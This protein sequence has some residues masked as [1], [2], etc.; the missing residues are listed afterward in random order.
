MSKDKQM[1]DALK[2]GDKVD[3]YFSVAYKKPVIEYKYG[4]MFEFRAADKSG[5][6]TVKYWG[7]QDHRRVQELQESLDRGGVA[8]ITGEV[9]EYRNQ[10]EISISEK[11]GYTVEVLKPGGYEAS[12]LV[13]TLDGIPEMRDRL[14]EFVHIVEEPH[15]VSL[16]RGFFEDEAFMESFSTC[17]A[18]IQLHSAAMGGLIHHTLNVA[19]ICAK[20]LQLQSG[21]D[22][23]LVI[24]GALLHDIGKTRSFEV[25]TN[26]NHTAEGNLLGHLIIGDE[27][28]VERLC[29][30]EGFPVDLSLKLRHV[31]ASHHGRKE[32]G[33]PV[34]PMMPEALLVHEA[35]DLD[36]KLNYMVSKR[37]GAITEDDWTWD[38]RLSR[39]IYLR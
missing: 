29:T 38:R 11:D 14:M 13:A 24:A 15:I 4:Y 19:E 26:I 32:W 39:L 18:S 1:I 9:G 35:D 25:T 36:A 28:L 37:E 5:Q 6:I 33:S 16:L 8:R 22:R 17:P 10:L 34:E 31:V 3:S 23:D 30:I 20:M 27:L 2:A 12:A 7:G 21:L